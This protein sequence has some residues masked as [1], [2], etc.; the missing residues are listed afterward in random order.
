MPAKNSVREY[1]TDA[2]YHIYNRGVE[3][4]RIF[5]DTDDYRFFISLLQRHLGASSVD[6][7][8][9]KDYIK[10]E[11]LSLLAYCLMPNH[12]HLMIYQ[13]NEP[14]EFS[15]LL[16][17]ISTAYTMYFN[18][19][20]DRVGHLFQDRFKASRIHDDG[21]YLHI[22]RYIH[23][24]PRNPFEYEWSS[25]PNYLGQRSDDWLD[26]GRVMGAFTNR[27]EYRDFV[28]DYAGHSEMIKAC[29][30][31]LADR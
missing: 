4:R 11:N 13:G 20:Y 29:K 25:L 19:K 5:I 24:N 9:G 2:Y 7:T 16:R 17:S 15:K 14:Q 26:Q 21:Y 30:R 1:D 6:D 22:T 31:N 3:K 18:K 28:S 8:R 23:L 12:F 10:F 27:Q